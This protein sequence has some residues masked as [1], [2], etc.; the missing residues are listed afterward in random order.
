MIEFLLFGLLFLI[1]V[2]VAV[3]AG[4]GI[5]DDLAGAVYSG[6]KADLDN[7][8]ARIKEIARTLAK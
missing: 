8:D 2:P 6:S 7:V 5:G 1:L 4:R 3:W